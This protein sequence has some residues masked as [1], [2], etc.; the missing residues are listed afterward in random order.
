MNNVIVV[1]NLYYL[2]FNCFKVKCNIL[3]KISS[4]KRGQSPL[5]LLKRHIQFTERVNL[6]LNSVMFY[7]HIPTFTQKKKILEVSK[8]E[9]GVV[10]S[11]L[12]FFSQRR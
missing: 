9:V 1:F 2:R 7:L 10:G 6:S 8:I 4:D 3:I 12:Q 5:L 11:L